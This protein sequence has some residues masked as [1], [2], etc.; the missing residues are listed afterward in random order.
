MHFTNV[1]RRYS[2]ES[3]RAVK[4]GLDPHAEEYN[5]NHKRRGVALVLNH[6]HF[7]SMSTRKGSEKDAENL[8][9]SLGNLGFDVRIYTDPTIKTISTVL[10]EGEYR[11]LP[12]KT[13]ACKPAALCRVSSSFVR[14][15]N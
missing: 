1:P 4:I 3:Q 5:M 2:Y 6:I 13:T 15:A 12:C 8:E 11:M 10:H 14:A 9:A 7:E